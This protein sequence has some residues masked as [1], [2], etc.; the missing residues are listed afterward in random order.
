MPRSTIPFISDQ[1]YHY[2]NRGNNHQAIFFERDN[3]LY[4]LLGIRKYLL[5]PWISWLI[6]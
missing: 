1:Y 4:F 6:V 2:Y 5:N 3:H